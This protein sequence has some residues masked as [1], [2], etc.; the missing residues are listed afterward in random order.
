MMRNGW[1]LVALVAMVVAVAMAACSSSSTG[2]G[3]GGTSRVLGAISAFGSIVVNGVTFDVDQAS[4]TID[5]EPSAPAD[6]QLG[7]VA[8]VSGTIDAGGRTGVAETVVVELLVQGPVQSVDPASG[9]IRAL[10]QSIL[11]DATTVFDGVSLP[12]L[13]PGDAIAVSG[14]FDAEGRIR[15]SRVS[16]PIEDEIA[17]IGTIQDLD[18]G[19]STFRLNALVVRFGSALI[20]NAPPGGLADG[21]LVEVDADDPPEDDVMDAIEVDAI[22]SFLSGDEGDLLEV[23]GFVTE[24]LGANEFVVNATQRVRFDDAT[25]FVRGSAADVVLNARLEAEGTADA[26][27]VLQATEIELAPDD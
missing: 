4:V 19:A 24:V 12:D 15:A 21:L 1:R 16:P 22:G 23:E 27:G 17:L 20:K 7:M 5:G 25:I 13:A 26:N 2:G 9:T 14:F 8:A 11:S 10:S 3:I 18:L 6:L